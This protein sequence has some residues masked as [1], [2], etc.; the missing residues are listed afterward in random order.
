MSHASNVAR[1]G[2]RAFLTA[3]CAIALS[4]CQGT[5]PS[6]SSTAP[7]VTSSSS[8]TPTAATPTV[9]SSAS[10]GAEVRVAGGVRYY[11]ID[12]GV[13]WTEPS[14]FHLSTGLYYVNGGCSGRDGELLG[15]TVLLQELREMDAAV[16]QEYRWECGPV[17]T[18]YVF[19][20]QRRLTDGLYRLV[21]ESNTSGGTVEIGPG[22]PTMFLQEAASPPPA[23]TAPTAVAS[24]VPCPSGATS[25]VPSVG[26][27]EPCVVFDLSWTDPAQ[28]TYRIYE[29]WRM[30]GAPLPPCDPAAA[31]LAIDTAGDLSA[32]TG[33]YV[34]VKAQGTCFWVAAANAAGESA[35]V[36]FE[37]TFE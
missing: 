19:G 4:G 17:E 27:Q 8:A 33:I 11:T 30:P 10:P 3:F 15:Q 32:R 7:S 29:T 37:I 20:E 21:I 25:G 31:V 14:P 22:S 5:S 9:V 34:P 13:N 16:E 12:P 6:A 2:I 23:P 1:P 26:W 24:V 18:A 28:A 36:E 35:H